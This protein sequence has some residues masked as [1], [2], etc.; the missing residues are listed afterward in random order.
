VVG[1]QR[2]LHAQQK[3]QSQNAEHLFPTRLLGAAPA[4]AKAKFTL[5]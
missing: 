4:R 3:T 1:F 5:V 2:V